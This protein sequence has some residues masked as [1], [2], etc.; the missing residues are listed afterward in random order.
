MSTSGEPEKALRASDAERE[1]TID[2]LRE[3]AGEGRL[4]FEELADRIEAVSQAVTRGDLVQ[5]T[6]DLPVAAAAITGAAIVVPTRKGT[7][8]LDVRRTG[9]WKVPVQSKW[10]SLFGDV[11]LDLREAQVTAPEV[12]IDAGTI[13]GDVD[14]LVPDGVAVEV[15]SRLLFGSVRQEAGEVAPA[16]APRVIL[17][18]GTVFG[19]V[20]VRSQRLRERWAGWPRRGEQAERS[21]G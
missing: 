6:A 7:V 20:R 11:V 15:R 18:G 12:T 9:T 1:R 2:L 16:G 19:D 5:L 14:L 3:A 8:F 4:T 13:F 10:E 21:K 17:T